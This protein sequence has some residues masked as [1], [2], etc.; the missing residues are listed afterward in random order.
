MA[1]YVRYVE[2]KNTG[3]L[4]FTYRYK[5]NDQV[6][7]WSIEAGIGELRKLIG[8]VFKNASLFTTKNDFI[9]LS[10][11]K[12]KVTLQTNKPTFTTT[13]ES[14]HDRQKVKRASNE[15][16]YLMHLGITDANGVLIQKM[17]DK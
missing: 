10:S 2:I 7:N 13:A 4:S 5:T 14:T 6:K 15:Q 17:A 3:T 16:A 9:L 12:G 1:I 11:K 8:S